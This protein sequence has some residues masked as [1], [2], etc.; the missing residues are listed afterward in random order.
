MI[1]KTIHVA[2]AVTFGIIAGVLTAENCCVEY[3]PRLGLIIGLLTSL[4]LWSL[5]FTI[6]SESYCGW[7]SW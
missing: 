2:V 3:R 7:S 6:T 5:L 4:T 1:S